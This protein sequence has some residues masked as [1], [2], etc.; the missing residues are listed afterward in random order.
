MKRLLIAAAL[1]ALA[2]T[3]A[4]SGH[5]RADGTVSSSILVKGGHIRITLTMRT[6]VQIGQALTGAYRVQNI[7]NA[8]RKIQL[9]EDRLSEVIRLPNGAKYDMR[10]LQ[11]LGGPVA[12]D[13]KLRPGQSVT[14]PIF[15]PRTRWNGPLQVTGSWDGHALPALRVTVAVPGSTPN[16]KTALQDV[17]TSTGHLLDG[18]AP[19]VPGRSV[20][21]GW[22]AAPKHS[23]PPLHAACSISLQRESGFVRAQ[24]LV[25]SP[26]SIRAHLQHPYELLNWLG[27][28][29]NATAV[30]WLFVVTKDGAISVDATSV[31]STRN[32]RRSAPGWQWTTSGFQP[33][34]G[35]TRCGGSGGG[36]GGYIGPYVEFVSKCR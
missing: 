10:A 29:R 32:A 25:V 28:G 27:S 20:T 13:T 33:Q 23:A 31:E 12:A 6:P 1:L 21:T 2:L 34:S 7:S 4:A 24:V 9:R 14:V 26:P 36:G 30:G 16:S 22:I 5:A 35:G 15:D 17:L 11:G 19:T 8:P 18:C 3:G